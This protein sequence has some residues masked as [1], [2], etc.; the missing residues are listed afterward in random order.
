MRESIS[1]KFKRLK[2]I[3]KELDSVVL[4]YSGGVDSSFLLAVCLNVLSEKVLAVTAVSSSYPARELKEAKR[5]AR[6]IKASHLIVRTNE[7]EDKNYIKNPPNRCYYCKKELFTKLHEIRKEYGMKHIVDGSNI[8]DESD[9][10]P[11]SIAKKEFG[12]CS[13]LKE[14]GLSKNDIRALSKKLDLCSWDSPSFAC[15]SSR[16]PY[17]TKLDT[18][19]LGRIEKAEDLLISLGFKQVRVR[20]FGNLAKIEVDKYKIARLVTKSQI[21]K[22]TKY[23]KKLGYKHITVDLEGYRMGSLNQGV[24]LENAIGR[25][26]AP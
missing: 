24:N 2:N 14:A 16:V 22:V 8:D 25:K 20:D 10:R 5:F 23:L 7:L 19:I 6:Q 13:P 21:Q 9:F 26:K 3:L 15:L 12:V 1:F 18:K 4:A 17:N 11:G